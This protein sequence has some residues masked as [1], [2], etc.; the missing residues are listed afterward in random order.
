LAKFVDVEAVETSV[1]STNKVRIDAR[2]S[3]LPAVISDLGAGRAYEIAKAAIENNFITTNP[4]YSATYIA[5]RVTKI[6]TLET[7]QA[8]YI[9]VL[10]N[11][12][13]TQ[14][15]IQ[16]AKNA[17]IAA[18]YALDGSTTDYPLNPSAV[19]AYWQNVK[20]ILDKVKNMVPGA[21]PGLADPY[22]KPPSISSSIIV[23]GKNGNTAF[24]GVAFNPVAGGYTLTLTDPNVTGAKPHAA[25][26]LSASD[27]T[28]GTKFY[29]AVHE[30]QTNLGAVAPPTPQVYI[31]NLKAY[32][33][34]GGTDV[35]AEINSRKQSVLDAIAAIRRQPDSKPADLAAKVA[36][37]NGWLG[38]ALPNDKVISEL[39]SGE[40]AALIRQLGVIE[41]IL[42]A[43]RPN[44]D[45]ASSLKTSDLV[46]LGGKNVGLQYSNFGMWRVTRT[47]SY[48]GDEK[49]LADQGM[50]NKTEYDDFTFYGGLDG[51]KQ[52]FSNPR[53]GIETVFRGKAMA[54]ASK[55]N[56]AGDYSRKEFTGDATLTLK[57]KAAN[58]LNTLKLSFEGWYDLTYANLDFS[59]PGGFSS[60]SVVFGGQGKFGTDWKFTNDETLFMS[61]T[62]G[63]EGQGYGVETNHPSE[64]VGS[65]QL[66]G[67]AYDPTYDMH[68]EGAYGVKR[69]N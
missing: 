29:T 34:G 42:S 4:D 17:V 8:D 36:L 31:T 12:G 46:T 54:M 11:G 55:T 64:V 22:I 52:G 35:Q 50:A 20:A 13:S 18:L 61:I 62:G 14:P 33:Y 40:Q 66:D 6:G 19:M 21:T 28:S 51:L 48:S 57:T 43:T 25:F 23:T 5:D 60:S 37:L 67:K 3:T 7:K 53:N 47:T 41:S 39:S 15:Q 9:A 32:V 38:T 30:V 63:V 58:P 49:Y 27:F 45:I 1:A 24:S 44:F 68:V 16:T 10:A 56:G 65:F 2:L 59:S 26:T 69:T